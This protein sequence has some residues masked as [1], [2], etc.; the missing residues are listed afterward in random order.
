MGVNGETRWI[1]VTDHFTRAV[2]GDARVSKAP[3]LEWLRSFLHLHSPQCDGEYVCLDQGGELYANPAVRGLFQQSRYDVRATGADASNQN[4]PVERAHR[5]VA[6]ALR[7]ML[8][9]AGL[10]LRFWPQAFHHF[11][12]IN[13]S[14]PSRDQDKSP[15]ELH[16]GTNE[17]FSGFRTFGCR[18]W[19]RPQGRR[20]VK[21][22]PISR[23]GIFLGFLPNTTKSI[24]WYDVDTGRIKIA[25]HV[26]FDEGLN[27]HP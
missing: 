4:G 24:L 7:A 6:N 18:V 14:T 10:D 27:D 1:L 2:F 13:N 9:G 19:V 26:R 17:D 25:K 22:R 12:R 3:P 15:Y 21:L 16:H 23:K 20:H 11:L 5:T 8:L